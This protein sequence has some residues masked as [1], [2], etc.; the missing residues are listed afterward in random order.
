[1]ERGAYDAQEDPQNCLTHEEM[2]GLIG[3]LH[4]HLT[5]NGDPKPAELFVLLIH[6][7]AAEKDRQ[8]RAHFHEATLHW[9]VREFDEVH[10]AER[11]AV[12]RIL[13]EF[14]KGGA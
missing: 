11:V 7:L 12:N 8:K 1:M 14:R 2:H 13:R 4:Y 9:F 3:E 10:D 6:S 5:K